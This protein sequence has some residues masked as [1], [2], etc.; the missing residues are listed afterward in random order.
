MTLIVADVVVGARQAARLGTGISSRVYREC[1]QK[2]QMSSERLLCG[3]KNMVDA[4][5]HRSELADWSE[6]KKRRSNYTRLISRLT[7]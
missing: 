3:G 2:E 1:Y 6:T 4:R 5:G 7:F